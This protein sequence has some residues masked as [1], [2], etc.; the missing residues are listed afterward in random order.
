MTIL[1]RLFQKTPTVSIIKGA[2]LFKDENENGGIFIKSDL[3]RDLLNAQQQRQAFILHTKRL[4]E[5]MALKHRLSRLPQTSYE[6]GIAIIWCQFKHGNV[7][8]NLC[9]PNISGMEEL[10]NAYANGRINVDCSFEDFIKQA[11]ASTDL[12]N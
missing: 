4:F 8:I 12:S 5:H 1:E 6:K 10:V 7:T 9:L 3:I 2:T 11:E